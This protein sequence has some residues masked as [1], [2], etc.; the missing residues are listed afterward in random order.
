MIPA[1]LRQIITDITTDT[2]KTE[3]RQLHTESVVSVEV[4][5]DPILRRAWRAARDQFLKRQEEIG[6][7]VGKQLVMNWLGD[8]RIIR[9]V[10]GK[11]T[12]D[13]LTVSAPI[14]H[15]KY[16]FDD[17]YS[18]HSGTLQLEVKITPELQ[19]ALKKYPARGPYYQ[20]HLSRGNIRA[21]GPV[22]ATKQHPNFL[23]ISLDETSHLPE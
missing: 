17:G 2:P 7:A 14:A 11:G 1:D 22:E 13:Q 12:P 19:N 4:A 5:N 8:A 18:Q 23:S 9:I 16:E 3:R 15:I 6:V 20:I 21:V 10:F